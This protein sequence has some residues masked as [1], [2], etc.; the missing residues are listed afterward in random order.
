MWLSTVLYTI[1]P[2]LIV[3]TRLLCCKLIE[4]TCMVLFLNSVF[5]CI[6]LW[7]CFFLASSKHMIIHF[8]ERGREGGKGKRKRETE[9]QREKHRLV[10]SCMRPDR[11]PNLQ[12]QAYARTGNG[13]RNL[14]VYRMMLQPTE[15]HQPGPIL[16][17]VPYFLDYYC[18]MIKFEFKKWDTSSFVLLSA[19]CFDYWGCFVVSYKF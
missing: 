6:D 1:Y 11:W 14:S 13:T 8:R 7:V 17:L 16:M 10:A 12:T 5:H 2:F 9:R 4:L 3:Y 19:D 15:P 18:V